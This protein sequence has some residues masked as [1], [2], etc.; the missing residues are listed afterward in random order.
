MEND[1]D[2]FFAKKDKSKKKTKS[3]FTVDDILQAKK[4]N[5][6]KLKKSKAKKKAKDANQPEGLTGLKIEGDD[7]EWVEIE[8][9]LEKDYTGLRVQNLQITGKGDDERQDGSSQKEEGDDD[10]RDAVQGPWKAL[11]TAPSN[12]SNPSNAAPEP[13]ATVVEPVA[14]DKEVLKTPGGKYVPPQMRR[15]QGETPVVAVTSGSS[16]FSA[17]G[18]K[19]APNVNSQEDFPTLGSFAEPSE[20]AAFERI[21]GGARQVDDPANQ[22]MKLSIGNKFDALNADD[23]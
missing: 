17:R 20:G 4:E 11:G 7:E 16:K 6:E 1:L 2:D 21:R 23:S 22:H 13:A 10:S 12:V 9:E 8:D 15:A 5:E 18:K 19:N 3:K 14:R